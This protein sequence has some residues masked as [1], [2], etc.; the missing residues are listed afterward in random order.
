MV[1]FCEPAVAVLLDEVE[2]EVADP[3]A[4]LIKAARTNRDK[5]GNAKEK[6]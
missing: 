2:G 4:E 3:Q 6:R 1:T 5:K